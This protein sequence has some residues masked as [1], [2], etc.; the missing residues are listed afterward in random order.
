[1]SSVLNDF[2]SMQ[3]KENLDYNHIYSKAEVL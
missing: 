2:F 1:M 3:D